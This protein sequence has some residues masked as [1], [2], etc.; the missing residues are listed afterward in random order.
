MDQSVI[1]IKSRYNK[2]LNLLR[3]NPQNSQY[4]HKVKKYTDIMHQQGILRRQIGGENETND[5]EKQKNI[6]EQQAIVQKIKNILERVGNMKEVKDVTDLTGGKKL[7]KGGALDWNFTLKTVPIDENTKYDTLKLQEKVAFNINESLEKLTQYK[8]A[9]EQKVESLEKE[10][11]R[12]TDNEKKLKIEINNLLGEKSGVS[13]QTE[14]VATN[15]SQAQVD[16][17]TIAKQLEEIELLRKQLTEAEGMLVTNKKNFEEELQK[18]KTVKIESIDKLGEEN[19]KN[20]VEIEKLKAQLKENE[21]LQEKLTTAEKILAEK[22]ELLKKSET[23]KEKKITDLQTELNTLR[24]TEDGLRI[25]LGK[26]EKELEENKQKI[27]QLGI[28]IEEAKKIVEQFVAA[29]NQLD[30]VNAKNVG[31]VKTLGNLF[32]ESEKISSEYKNSLQTLIS[33]IQ[34]DMGSNSTSLAWNP[35]PPASSLPNTPVS[36]STTLEPK[37]VNILNNLSSKSTT[38]SNTQ[39]AQSSTLTK[40]A[41][42]TGAVPIEKIKLGEIGKYRDGMSDVEVKTYIN[43][44]KDKYINTFEESERQ[45]IYSQISDLVTKKTKDASQT[46]KQVASKIHNKLTSN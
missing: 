37:L 33:A 38:Q 35:P 18:L 39:S 15:I 32:Q 19:K 26:K 20:I 9:N 42:V 46:R 43:A 14:Q 24:A 23:D 36:S 28:D 6:E 34:Q 45:K 10:I 44:N 4:M 12:L 1:T 41:Q 11:Q 29:N 2:Y 25:N 22:E 8:T 40:L 17:T 16:A 27:L 5:L 13:V 30:E 7:L 21:K 31:R 3:K